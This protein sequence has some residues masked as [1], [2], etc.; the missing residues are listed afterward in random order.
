M[1]FMAPLKSFGNFNCN[2]LF[3]KKEILQRYCESS[4]DRNMLTEI[5]EWGKH[6]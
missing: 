3:C 4:D 6:Y 1:C 2:I 5:S